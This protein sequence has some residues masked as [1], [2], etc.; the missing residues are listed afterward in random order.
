M[1]MLKL[2]NLKHARQQDILDVSLS[3]STSGASGASFSNV[4]L[5]T[6]Y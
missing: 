1:T 4:F 3:T 6:G 5:S 2:V